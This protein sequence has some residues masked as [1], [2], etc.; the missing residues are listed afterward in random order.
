LKPKFFP[1]PAKWRQWLAAHHGSTAELWVGFHRKATGK[2]S[3]T[4]PESV[5]Q[6]LCYGWIDGIRK[7]LNATSYVIRFTPRR[8]RSTWSTVN[9][10]RAKDLIRQG[11]MRA[12]GLRAFKARQK[13][14][15]GVYSSEQ[16]QAAKLPPAYQRRLKSN[17]GAWEYFQAQPPGYRRLTS[18]WVISA[19]REETRLKRLGVLIADSA[20]GRRIGVIP[21]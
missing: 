4:W 20:S 13:D 16:R 5:D 21:P 8:K 18:W 12:P 7:T 14:R 2:P 6:A 1:T 9:T 10:R 11:V 17:A 15:S 19:K 3:I